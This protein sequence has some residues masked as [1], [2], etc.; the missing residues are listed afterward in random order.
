MAAYGRGLSNRVVRL[1]NG[2]D[3]DI[4]DRLAARLAAIEERGFDVGP[5]T[6]ERLRLLMAEIRGINAAV[7]AQ[8]GDVAT[9]ELEQLAAAEA[10]FHRAAINTALGV[11]LATGLPSPAR[12]RAIVTTTPIQGT[13]LDAWVEG[14]GTARVQRIEQAVRLG[15]VAG[16]GTDRIVA[17]VR[18]T[19]ANAYRDGILEVSRR[20]AQAMVRTAVNHTSN[21]AAQATWAA[22]SH[23]I[24]SWAFLA[25]L[26]GRTTP[27]CG[28]L[29]GQT[30]P[31]GQGPIPPLHL[32]CRSITVPVTR[33]ARELG[34][35]A[36]EI[37][38]GKRASMDGQVAGRITYPE[39]L[40]GK[41]AAF[42]DQVLGQ[43]R[44]ALFR[45]GKLEFSDLM[46]GDGSLL[47]LDQLRAK[48]PS[49]L[50]K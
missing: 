47:T 44:A 31:L 46:R 20:S 43:Q 2:A 40:R 17:R 12:L 50:D 4:L 45:E 25:T 1:L 42:Q 36:D 22:N 10:V 21:Q 11:E 19:R 28:S 8:V 29:D 35:D 33:T 23:V 41:G 24:A 16:E 37:P 18:G 49:L 6:T 39:W 26:D 27:R 15:V 5:R 13:L 34:V 9:T 32:S 7:Y 3:Q 48:Y 30:F 38:P 14:M